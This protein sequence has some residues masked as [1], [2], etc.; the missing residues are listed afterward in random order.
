MPAHCRKKTLACPL[1]SFPPAS[2]SVA[3]PRPE[4]FHLTSIIRMCQSTTL[5]A[6]RL[7]QPLLRHLVASPTSRVSKREAK[8]NLDE[9]GGESELLRGGAA[10]REERKQRG[11]GGAGLG[12]QPPPAVPP[13]SAREPWRRRAGA[14]RVSPGSPGAGE[15]RSERAVQP[16]AG[17]Q[18]PVPLVRPPLLPR[19]RS[20]ASASS[21]SC[22]GWKDLEE[23]RRGGGRGG[24][25]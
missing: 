4:F 2:V 15:R 20:R 7:G 1:V 10:G 14:E 17:I 25:E 24:E 22:R 13:P 21:C 3:A 5:Q 18:P 12:L 8:G 11:R 6:G 19:P 16:P 23:G 9:S